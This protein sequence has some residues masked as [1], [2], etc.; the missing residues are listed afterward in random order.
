MTASNY[1]YNRRYGVLAT[2]A[3][4]FALMLFVASPD[5]AEAFGGSKKKMRGASELIRKQAP[6]KIT[7]RLKEKI[8]PENAYVIISLSKQRAYL[9]VDGETYIDTPISSGKRA[10]MTPTGKFEVTEKDKDHRS[11]IYGN[12]VDSKGR[13]VRGGISLK[14]DSAPAG[15]HYV[16]APMWFFMRLTGSGVG[17]HIGILP[18]YPASH[19]CIRLPEEIA[20]LIYEKVKVG[21]PVTIEP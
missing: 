18:G 12:F 20:P 21:T 8:N 16:G 17:M 15:T 14:I 1:S 11:S 6:P 3:A 10:G 7:A 13:V 2:F 5:R 4:A 19:G 9:M